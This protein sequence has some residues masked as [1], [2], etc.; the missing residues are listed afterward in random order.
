MMK[1][2][3]HYLHF[4]DRPIS[5]I[6]GIILTIA[7]FLLGYF[8]VFQREELGVGSLLGLLYPCVLIVV[9]ESIKRRNFWPFWLAGA[10]VCLIV[11]SQFDGT[12]FLG[13]LAVNLYWGLAFV[14]CCSLVLCCSRAELRARK[15]DNEA[16]VGDVDIDDPVKDAFLEALFHD[17]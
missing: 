1:R 6:A 7:Y 12:T 13:A 16:R 14:C 8:V 2:N 15:R 3:R 11:L 4:S 5:K 9:W 17:E 10:C